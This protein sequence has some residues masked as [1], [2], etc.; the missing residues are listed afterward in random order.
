M[1][2]TAPHLPVLLNPVVETLIGSRRDAMRVIDGTLGYGGHS[3]AILRLN[4]NA[5]VLGIDRDVEALAFAKKR[6]AFAGDRIIFAHGTFADLEKI[7]V[8]HGWDSVDA[9]LLDIGVSSPQID[10][11]ERGFSHRKTGPLDMRMNRTDRQTASHL[12]NHSDVQELTDIFRNYGEIHQAY[13]LACAVVEQRGIKPFETT[14]ELAELCERT[15]ARP[16]PG[17]LPSPTLCF[18]A[19]RI[20]VNDE[21]RQLDLALPAA[22]KILKAGGRMGVISFHSL[23]DRRVKE[24]F[25]DGASDCICP[26]SFPVCCCKHRAVLRILTKKPV[27]ADTAELSLNPRASCAKFRVAEKL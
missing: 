12:L 24:F 16:R 2:E 18:Q 11:A 8:A 3:E 4:P 26:P 14:A 10:Q 23:E 21:L 6:L 25:A 20:A 17:V 22:L 9:V 1:S 19:L 13:K 15:L 27:T 5:Q 7:A